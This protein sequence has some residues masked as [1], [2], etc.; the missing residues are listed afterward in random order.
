M[1]DAIK[2]II[3]GAGM[4]GL[5]GLG[6]CIWLLPENLFFPG[7]TMLVGAIVCGVLG[8]IY[9]D[10]FFEWLGENWHHWI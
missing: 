2:G 3:I 9:G 4:G 10:S 8:H 7:D 1:F 5:A 6:V